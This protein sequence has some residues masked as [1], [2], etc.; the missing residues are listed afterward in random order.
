MTV[1]NG[2]MQTIY[3]SENH[4]PKVVSKNLQKG[5]IE[6]VTI[7]YNGWGTPTTITW[8]VKDGSA[9]V[10]TEAL[11]SNL[12]TALITLTDEGKSLIKV[13]ATDGT[14]T[15]S[16]WLKVKAVDEN[17]VNDYGVCDYG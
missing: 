1:Y 9:T 14:K 17:T 16:L 15:N 5:D 4:R 10:G 8:S 12:A 3:V 7:D 13:T 6:P 2:V 11:S